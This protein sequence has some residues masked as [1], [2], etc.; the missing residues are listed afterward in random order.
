MDPGNL[1]NHS[2]IQAGGDD[3]AVCLALE[4]IRVSNLIGMA[5][6]PAGAGSR[7]HLI[8][9]II[10]RTLESKGESLPA[11]PQPLMEYH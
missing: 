6:S 3:R 9:R 11:L 8:R 7:P 1:T 2:L 4:R 5:E 10:I